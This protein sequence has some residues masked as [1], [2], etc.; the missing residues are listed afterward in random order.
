MGKE[1]ITEIK[2]AKKDKDTQVN[3]KKK[4]FFKTKRSFCCG[5]AETN[6]NSIREDSGS[7]P[8]VA[9]WVRD[10]VLP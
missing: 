9:Q 6:P 10:P 3:V 8:G 1:E 4:F 7:I 2:K 5:E